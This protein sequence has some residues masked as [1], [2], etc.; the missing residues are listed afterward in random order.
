MIA[1]ESGDGQVGKWVNEERNYYLDYKR[2]FGEEPPKLRAVAVMTDTDD[3]Q[4]ES[5]AWYGDIFLARSNAQM[6]R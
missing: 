4:D 3:T 6:N 5:T 1:A 2:I